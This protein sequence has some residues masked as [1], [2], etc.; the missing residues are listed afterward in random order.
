MNYGRLAVAAVS[1]TVV[2]YVYGFVVE[3]LLIRKDFAPYKAVYRSADTVMGYMPMGMACTLIAT[4][5]IAIFVREPPRRATRCPKCCPLWRADRNLCSLYFRRPQL[6][7]PQPR[8]ETSARVSGKRDSPVDD[9]VP[10]SRI[11]IAHC[12]GCDILAYQ[13]E[14]CAKLGEFLVSATPTLA[15]CT[16]GRIHRTSAGS[17][18]SVVR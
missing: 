5:I 11:H 2:Y 17:A 14:L 4:F 9:C 15:R 12:V 16:G 3:G 1:A 6:C 8:Q 7:D 10:R 18:I 13:A